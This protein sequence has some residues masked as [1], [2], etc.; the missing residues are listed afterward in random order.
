MSA[1]IL[2]GA[3][4]VCLLHTSSEC[5]GVAPAGSLLLDNGR[6]PCYIDGPKVNGMRCVSVVGLGAIRHTISI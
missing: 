6:L 1:S 2:P 5:C 3:D 4:H